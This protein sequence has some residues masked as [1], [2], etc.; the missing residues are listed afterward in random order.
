M[1]TYDI[2]LS[3]WFRRSVSEVTRNF[4]PFQDIFL[5]LRTV[6][7]HKTIVCAARKPTIIAA[8]RVTG[9]ACLFDRRRKISVRYLTLLILIKAALHAHVV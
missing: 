3:Q 1:R 6:A 7:R 8:R 5:C 4:I 9:F 2:D